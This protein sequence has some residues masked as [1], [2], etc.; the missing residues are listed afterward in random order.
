MNEVHSHGHENTKPYRGEYARWSTTH[1]IRVSYC[2][3]AIWEDQRRHY[4]VLDIEDP[5]Y[6]EPSTPA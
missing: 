3:V 1:E 2:N 5:E 4:V 6:K